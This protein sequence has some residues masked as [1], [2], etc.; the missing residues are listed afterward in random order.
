MI[1]AVK[2]MPPGSQE[3]V[4][5][6]TISFLVSDGERIVCHNRPFKRGA[7]GEEYVDSS[8]GLPLR[9]RLAVRP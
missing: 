2:K 9:D 8:C 6:G 4:R 3:A 5:T 1:K 7:E